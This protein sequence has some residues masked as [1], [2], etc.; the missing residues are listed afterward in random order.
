MVLI[1]KVKIVL[2][3]VFVVSLAACALN[4]TAAAEPATDESPA[5]PTEP[6]VTC[7]DI[8]SNWGQD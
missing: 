4:P 1:G 7:A 6:V 3:S 5:T 8:D 2:I